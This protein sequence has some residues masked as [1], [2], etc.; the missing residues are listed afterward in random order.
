MKDGKRSVEV[1][2]G[3]DVHVKPK[4]DY[5]LTQK[6]MS[7]KELNLIKRKNELARLMAS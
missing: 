4:R 7:L 2:K 3:S 5:M 6:D 1:A